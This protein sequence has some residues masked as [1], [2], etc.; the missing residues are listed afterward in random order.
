[1]VRHITVVVDM[2]ENKERVNEIER[3]A[4]ETEVVKNEVHDVSQVDKVCSS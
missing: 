2:K 4:H 1:M 3:E